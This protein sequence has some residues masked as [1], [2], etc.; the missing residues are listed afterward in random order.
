MILEVDAMNTKNHFDVTVPA[1]YVKSNLFNPM[2]DL[3]AGAMK[4]L[5]DQGKNCEFLGF[6]A[7]NGHVLLINGVKY[8]TKGNMVDEMEGF[9][10]ERFFL[11]LDENYDYIENRHTERLNQIRS[12]L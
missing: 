10:T 6:N 5:K 11:L 3:F 2:D 9:P 7:L 12:T 8:Y 1:K 4:S